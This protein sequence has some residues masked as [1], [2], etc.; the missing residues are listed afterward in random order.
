MD[1]LGAYQ[2]IQKD[3]TLTYPTQLRRKARGGGEEALDRQCFIRE[4]SR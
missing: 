1:I 4:S 3:D 2:Y